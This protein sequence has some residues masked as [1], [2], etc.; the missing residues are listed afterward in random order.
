LSG[1]TQLMGWTKPALLAALLAVACDHSAPPPEPAPRLIGPPER[2]QRMYRAGY[3]DGRALEIAHAREQLAAK[4]T[5]I[6]GLREQARLAESATTTATASQRALTSCETELAS[7]KVR[8]A[9]LEQE[10]S[11][12]S[13]RTPAPASLGR[14]EERDPEPV[15]V[16]CCKICRKGKACG[17]SCISRAY[18]CHK[19]PGCAC[20][21]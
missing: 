18:E 12:T 16:P 8:V 14:S 6:S 5:E 15:S 1:P 10:A 3:Q 20:D 2:E 13:S 11:R 17:N 19:G 7:S 9:E 21:G 4:D